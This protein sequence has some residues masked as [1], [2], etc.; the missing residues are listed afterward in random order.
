MAV[1]PP[2]PC[3]RSTNFD[4][5]GGT[6][7][8]GLIAIM[9]GKL[10]MDIDECI[11]A[12]VE[13]ISVVFAVEKSGGLDEFN[14]ITFKYNGDI[15]NR[16]DSNILAKAIES[17][18]RHKGASGKLF[19]DP[20]QPERG[21]K[22]Y[23]FVCATPQKA[24]MQTHSLQSYDP[25]PRQ[26]FLKPTILRAAL[27]TSA[28]VTLFEPANV[29]SAIGA[30]STTTYVDGALGANNPVEELAMEASNCLWPD[31]KQFIIS[32]GTGSKKFGHS[33]SLPQFAQDVYHRFN[34][35][36][37]LQDVGIFEYDAREDIVIMARAYLDHHTIENEVFKCA[38]G[39]A[40]K[41]DDSP[42]HESSCS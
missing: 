2:K 32:I 36:Q 41:P 28:A 7:T 10:E 22:T 16:F 26:A 35:E 21:C 24:A 17:I 6:S 9:L 30:H 11:Q 38:I 39:L 34:V 14:N 20:N 29:P 1:K 4:L 31:A 19:W 5:I 40:M 13:L 18:L 37:G 25:K 23:V 42:L 27:A 8:G 12:Y 3:K 33:R 15:S